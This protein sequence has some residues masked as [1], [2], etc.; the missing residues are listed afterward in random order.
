[1]EKKR[2][3]WSAFAE[4]LGSLI[5]KYYDVLDIDSLQDPPKAEIMSNDLT[6]VPKKH[7]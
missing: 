1:M 2:D 6:S 7:K 4:M 5:A 3:E